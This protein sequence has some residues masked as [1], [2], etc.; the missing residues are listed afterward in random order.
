[1]TEDFGIAARVK[2]I[3]KA[4]KLTLQ[5][6]ADGS[7]LAKSYVW[8]IENSRQTNPSISTLVGLTKA[9]GTSLDALVGLDTYMAPQLRPEAMQIA[10]QVDRLLRE[11]LAKE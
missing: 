9:L 7:G 8:E 11:A 1:M 6:V 2:A 5:E 3:R 10:V 4:R